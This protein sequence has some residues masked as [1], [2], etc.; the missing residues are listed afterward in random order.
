M[1]WRTIDFSIILISLFT[2][3]SI[4]L[5]SEPKAASS[6]DIQDA[7]FGRVYHVHKPAYHLDPIK[8]SSLIR[9]RNFL[10]DFASPLRTYRLCVHIIPRTRCSSSILPIT[11]APVI[12]AVCGKSSKKAQKKQSRVLL[13]YIIDVYNWIFSLRIFAACQPD[14]INLIRPFPAQLNDGD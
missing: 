5:N 9:R 14:I 7:I 2:P 3:L 8:L 4:S 12:T 6:S 10:E 1:A 13:S 11:A